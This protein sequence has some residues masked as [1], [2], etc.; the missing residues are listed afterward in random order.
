VLTEPWEK[1]GG[2]KIVKMPFEKMER[3]I[4]GGTEL[5]AGVT[6]V[7][8]KIHV[9]MR[10]SSNNSVDAATLVVALSASGNDIIEFVSFMQSLS[11]QGSYKASDNK[12]VGMS[13]G[14]IDDI[15]EDTTVKALAQA[16]AGS[17]L[18]SV[19]TSFSK[20]A[21]E[22]GEEGDDDGGVCS[23]DDRRRL[24]TVQGVY[25]ALSSA[26]I[27]HI[28]WATLGLAMLLSI[29]LIFV[30]RPRRNKKQLQVTEATKNGDVAPSRKLWRWYGCVA[31]GAAVG[32]LMLHQAP[33]PAYGTSDLTFQH[34]SLATSSAYS[35]N[36]TKLNRKLK[37]GKH[38][39]LKRKTTT[40]ATTKTTQAAD[41]ASSSDVE[42][43]RRTSTVSAYNTYT[44]RGW[45]GGGVDQYVGSTSTAQTCWERCWNDYYQE[46]LVS[47]DWWAYS[48]SCYCQVGR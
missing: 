27:S 18:V 8:H 31:V 25:E 38:S 41:S 6:K 32:G 9:T 40:R 46:S 21:R 7:T 33:L 16:T 28:F 2:D 30:L 1:K 5:Q 22:A 43:G 23:E 20:A 48:G 44:D 26:S 34:R 37:V 36:N 29:T 12:G 13:A 17:A 15:D 35:K 47:I 4:S 45:C 14:I 19:I 10:D 3:E 24:T 39:M 11:V 42:E